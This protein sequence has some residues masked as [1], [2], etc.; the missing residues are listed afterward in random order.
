MMDEMSKLQEAF[1]DEP[2][3][4]VSLEILSPEEDSNDI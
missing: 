2:G 3:L 1:K 4:E